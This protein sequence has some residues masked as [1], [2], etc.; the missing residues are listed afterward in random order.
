MQH[1][2][3]TDNGVE[4]ERELNCCP[5]FFRLQLRKNVLS[6]HQKL[7]PQHPVPH[8][9][10]LVQGYRMG[11]LPM[12]ILPLKLV[13]KLATPETAHFYI[14]MYFTAW[15]MDAVCGARY[16]C[17]W[18][19]TPNPFVHL[20]DRI[21]HAEG[22]TLAFMAEH[23]YKLSD[24]P[25]LVAYAKE[26]SQDKMA[27]DGVQLG[28]ASATYKMVHGIGAV[29]RKRL[30]YQMQTNCFSLNLDEATSN[31]NKKVLSVMVAYFSPEKG[32]TIV[33]H[34]SSLTLTI[35]SAKTITD[36]IVKL[37]KDDNI[38]LS[39]FI[40]VLCDSANYMRGKKGGFETLLRQHHANHLLDIDGDVCHHIHNAS[41]RFCSHFNNV[42]E[43]LVDDLHT[44]FKF[45]TDLRQYLEEICN[46]LQCSFHIPKQRGP[47]RWLSVLDV[48]QPSE[49]MLDALTVMYSAWLPRNERE[50]YQSVLDEIMEGVST[51]NLSKLSKIIKVCREKN[52]T[53]DGR[54]RKKR[55]VERIFYTRI[56]TFIHIHLYLSLLPMFKSFI[57]TFEQR[58]PM[59]HRA[60]EEH[61]E[62]ATHFLACF[63]KTEKIKNITA[64]QIKSLQ[65]DAKEN[66]ED[67][68]NMYMGSKAK[69]LL[70]KKKHSK[71]QFL[72]KLQTAYID[73]GKYLVNKLP[74]VNVTLQRLAAVDPIAVCSGRSECT[75]TMKKLV[76]HFPTVISSDEDKDAYIHEV[77]RINSDP[78]L[79][80]AFV[81]EKAVRADHWWAAV[82]DGYPMLGKVVK[83][84]LSII[85][86][87]VVEQHFSLMN[88]YIN[89]K[90]NR[91][92]IKTFSAVQTV[93]FHLQSEGKSS[94][95]LFHR[96][97]VLH[98]PVDTA[99][100]YHLQTSW[101]KF[102]KASKTKPGSDVP[103]EQAA[104]K[105]V[106]TKAAE[107]RNLVMLPKNLKR[108]NM[109]KSGSAKK[110]KKHVAATLTTTK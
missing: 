60:H 76:H 97:N 11:H 66:L 64:Q 6:P 102:K 63:V 52:L 98:S 85:T 77:L 31:N 94:L 83:A 36:S 79:P 105:S 1:Q 43:R 21:S 69:K 16:D 19:E 67:L 90:T 4:Q 39:N 41:R 55:I 107:L 75:N 106:Q 26:M 80:P 45:S 84:C 18:I 54:K 40:S 13:S 92:E 3:A 12:F 86:A 110:Q 46:I 61:M 57:I 10:H 101:S 47:H 17:H 87:P 93:K 88:N 58:A 22:R 104:K 99:L 70:A 51:S 73:S 14:I 28:R 59:V 53:E 35:V 15:F 24:A 49:E 34:Y 48:L 81:D 91:L 2:K 23:N 82:V 56:D 108:K 29:A 78:M 42:V 32:E 95:E 30:V 9:H 44:E 8:A 65:I 74:L 50:V 71:S 25:H 37:L 38:P 5:L 72:E 103:P 7:Q 68:S 20:K 96:P 109:T 27:L 33:Q 89:Q 62:L 100:C